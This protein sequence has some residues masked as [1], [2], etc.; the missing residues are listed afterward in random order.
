MRGNLS[1]SHSTCEAPCLCPEK[2]PI[3]VALV[4]KKKVLFHNAFLFRFFVQFSLLFFSF[5]QEKCGVTR[6][7]ETRIAREKSHFPPALPYSVCFPKRLCGK[8][9]VLFLTWDEKKCRIG[10]S[11]IGHVAQFSS[12]SSFL[13]PLSPKKKCTTS[14]P[15]KH[16]GQPGKK[17]KTGLKEGE[18]IEEALFCLL[19]VSPLAGAE[20]WAVLRGQGGGHQEE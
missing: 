14:F 12:L 1:K 16:C 4:G 11:H 15:P 6:A 10:E 7:G 8:M 18:T 19:T 17:R 5:F 13:P 9:A 20:H 2:L 3:E